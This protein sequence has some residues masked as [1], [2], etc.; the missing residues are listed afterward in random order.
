MRVVREKRRCLLLFSAGLGRPVLR[1]ALPDLPLSP[2]ALLGPALWPRGCPARCWLR[3]LA[4][5]ARRRQA[6]APASNRQSKLLSLS[7][8]STV[9]FPQLLIWCDGHLRTFF[10]SSRLATALRKHPLHQCW[11]SERPLPDFVVHTGIFGVER[12]ASRF[13]SRRNTFARYGHGDG[14]VGVAVKAPQRRLQRFGAVFGGLASTTRHCGGE[15]VGTSREYV[16]NA[17]A[18]HR[19]TCDVNSPVVNGK[20]AA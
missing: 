16:P 17:R 19:L 5:P 3:T 15:K 6:Q 10:G 7:S 18:A 13:A 14:L 20:F 12:V 2:R 11:F 8:C 4:E 1:F 9:S